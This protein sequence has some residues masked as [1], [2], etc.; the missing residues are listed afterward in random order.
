MAYMLQ[1]R[2]RDG[3]LSSAKSDVVADVVSAGTSLAARPHTACSTSR[4]RNRQGI[5]LAS[6]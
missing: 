1:R 3:V 2:S 4:R 5:R 6:R